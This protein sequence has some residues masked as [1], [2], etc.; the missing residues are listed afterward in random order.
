M[1]T[2]STFW[3][4]IAS[5]LIA[6]SCSSNDLY[7]KSLPEDKVVSLSAESL[8]MCPTGDN[9][10]IS[11]TASSSWSISTSGTWL[12]LSKTSGK[13][14][15]YLVKV[16]ADIN[17]TR[18][19]RSAIIHFISDDV[20]RD[21]NVYQECPYLRVSIANKGEQFSRL[22]DTVLYKWND[23]KQM[24]YPASRI[25]I[26]SN[27]DWA[28]N[29]LGSSDGKD[30]FHFSQSSGFGSETVEMNIPENNTGRTHNSMVLHIS[31]MMPDKKEIIGDGVD[32]YKF[33][34]EQNNLRF[35]LNDQYDDLEV[36]I[37]E[38]NTYYIG[39]NIVVD[40]ELP[41]SIT[42]LPNWLKYSV[43]KDNTGY[44]R[45][46]LCFMA[47][48]V[49]PSLMD[50]TASLTI[51]S[52]GGV[53]RGIFVDQTP[54]I[55]NLSTDQY[56]FPN[57][58]NE[59]VTFNIE[60]SGPWE[61]TDIPQWLSISP[62]EGDGNATVSL[63][64]ADQNFGLQDLVG[65]VRF[66]SKLNTI[67]KD[68][69]VK[70]EKFLFEIIPDRTLSSIPV[71]DVSYYP[72]KVISSGKWEVINNS[73]WIMSRSVSDSLFVVGANSFNP[74]LNSS[75][76]D[77]LTIE[78][79]DH[80]DHG[81][82]SK[83][84]KITQEKL[85]FNIISFDKTVPAYTTNKYLVKLQS[86]VPWEIVS[87]PTWLKP[88]LD[89]GE[90]KDS[91][92][93]FSVVTNK[94]MSVSPSGTIDIK[95]LIDGEHDVTKS[96]GTLVQDKFVFNLS[97]VNDGEIFEPVNA[98]KRSIRINT[99]ESAGWHIATSGASIGVLSSVRGNGSET[100]T[101]TLND[102][103]SKQSREQILT[104]YS[105][106]I[107]SAIPL[108]FSQKQFL[109]SCNSN[110]RYHYET[111]DTKHDYFN[112]TCSGAWSISATHG[113]VHFSRTNGGGSDNSQ[114]IEFWV[115]K[116][117]NTSERSCSV[118]I[119][120]DLH[121][122]VSSDFMS[123]FVIDQDKYIFDNT[124]FDSSFD[125]VPG[126]DSKTL[127]VSCTGSWQITDIPAWLSVSP[128]S[129][130]GN[131]DITISASINTSES[132]RVA[133]M[134]V[135]SKDNSALIKKVSITQKPYVFNINQSTVKPSANDTTFTMTIDCSGAWSAESSEPSWLSVSPNSTTSSGKATVTIA[136]KSNG[137]KKEREGKIEITSEHKVKKTVTI[138]QSDKK[139]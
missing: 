75:R 16:S 67:S 29:S 65:A 81:G 135:V 9:Y 111:L 19:D 70:Q 40:S 126:N 105:D 62:A 43:S 6:I 90:P 136:V 109:F 103:L 51:H 114:Q 122:G 21:M 10:T 133:E 134:K 31:A 129:G 25:I 53:D 30:A 64:C 76:S 12:T 47:D 50:R 79:L 56:S 55:F 80:R 35:L 121:N 112:L 97:N 26:E 124:P 44:G 77:I 22:Q 11:F 87:C 59:Q 49:N 39:N 52:E 82:L 85:I 5:L 125:E 94:S 132:K 117:V 72:V 38:L 89:T 27:V 99:T 58:G 100:V 123:T 83:T 17:R 32:D 139:K 73:G 116:N 137:T 61:I 54:Y 18:A 66:Q 23:T 102:N 42:N 69:R 131:K 1:K 37:N 120:S 4:L 60:S 88:E 119:S 84:I 92:L 93:R 110:S 115:D 33:L 68:F 24:S 101:Y 45:D 104:I 3:L 113:W 2:Y 91:V 138:I 106:V 107:G 98:G 15:T 13:E 108:S 48:G 130:N 41:W 95:C 20:Q 74:D 7:Q 127:K 128:I 86:T 34:L 57:G 71:K 46:T 96:T 8:T 78:S 28:L 63:R 118:V 36:Y 14:G